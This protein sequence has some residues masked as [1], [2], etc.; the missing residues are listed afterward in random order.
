MKRTLKVFKDDDVGFDDD[1]E[2]VVDDD[3]RM[4]EIKRMKRTLK[5]TFTTNIVF[6]VLF[7]FLDF[8]TEVLFDGIRMSPL[9]G[10]VLS[11]VQT[12]QMIE[13]FRKC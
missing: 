10:I 6:D 8:C 4:S 9:S 12:N 2:E 1:D 7:L 3:D 11:A 5:G 13:S